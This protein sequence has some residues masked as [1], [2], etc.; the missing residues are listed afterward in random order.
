MNVRIF[1]VRATECMCAQTTPRFILSFE[2]DIMNGVRTLLTLRK[3]I[4]CTGKNSSLDEDPNYD[5]ASRRTA[6]PAHY[7]MS[8][9]GPSQ[10]YHS[11]WRAGFDAWSD[12]LAGLVVK[13][14]TS[15]AEDPGVESYQ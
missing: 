6:S 13:A 7:Q 1:Y 9:A 2:R 8:Y 4:P 3:K 14:S 5:A 11:S 15:R 12:R 10:W